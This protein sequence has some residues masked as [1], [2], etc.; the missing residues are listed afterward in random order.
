MHR[1]GGGAKDGPRPRL[2]GPELTG[3]PE[4]RPTAPSPAYADAGTASEQRRAPEGV[5]VTVAEA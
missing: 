3:C 2:S 4:S 1:D 5:Q